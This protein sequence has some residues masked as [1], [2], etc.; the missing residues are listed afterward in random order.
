VKNTQIVAVAHESS[1][2][3]EGAK[4]RTCLAVLS[5]CFVPLC[6]CAFV[7]ALM[8]EPDVLNGAERVSGICQAVSRG[9]FCE[10]R[11][12]LDRNDP[13][14]GYLGQMER[15]VAGYEQIQLQRQSSRQAAYEKQLA[16]LEAFKAG[17][18]VS[19]PDRSTEDR[20]LSEGVL[21]GQEPSLSDDPNG[22]GGVLAVIT[23][24]H[25][26]ADERQKARLLADPFVQDKIGQALAHAVHRYRADIT[27]KNFDPAHAVE[28]VIELVDGGVGR[29][30]VEKFQLADWRFDAVR[31]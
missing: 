19:R 28:V 22:Y 4:K 1:A 30:S 11:R 12:L 17:R 21:L 8:A 26:L 31:D 13:K 10:A 24:A 14:N 27:E 16:E 3:A 9:D 25:A 7:P 6:L 23:R 2:D 5:L 15:I 20:Q 18:E 29:D